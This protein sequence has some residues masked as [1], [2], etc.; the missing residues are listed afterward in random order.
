M[1]RETEEGE[2][3]REEEWPG[4]HSTHSKTKLKKKSNEV[5]GSA[6]VTPIFHMEKQARRGQRSFRK[7]STLG[8]CTN[9]S[10]MA[11]VTQTAVLELSVCRARWVPRGGESENE[12]S[13]KDLQVEGIAELSVE[14]W[15][16]S[17]ES[18]GYRIK[19]WSEG[20]G[21]RK[22]SISDRN[23]LGSRV[24][25]LQMDASHPNL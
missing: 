21:S 1:W 19:G 5:I 13:G 14:R 7:A 24:A 2:R 16:V 25:G 8:L 9:A 23:C 15:E 10:A 6:I 22:K 4:V 18:K 11:A 17:Q 12:V 20:R 3:Q